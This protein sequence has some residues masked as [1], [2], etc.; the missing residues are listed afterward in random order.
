MLSSYIDSST[1]KAPPALI[2]HSPD[3][4]SPHA[5]GECEQATHE[6]SG[7]NEESERDAL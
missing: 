5:H 7:C 4:F 1:W 3:C 6:E 2:W